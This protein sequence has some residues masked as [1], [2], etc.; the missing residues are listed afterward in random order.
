[1]NCIHIIDQVFESRIIKCA[2]VVCSEQEEYELNDVLGA[3]DY[4]QS[5]LRIFRVADIEQCE[6][7]LY[8]QK[9]DVLFFTSVGTL[10]EYVK[11]KFEDKKEQQLLICI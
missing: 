3:K 10:L 1:M 9:C 7:L 6:N 5:V 2:S 4:S 11:I 8:I